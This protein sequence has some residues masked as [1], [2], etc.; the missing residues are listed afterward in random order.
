MSSRAGK[1]KNQIAQQKMMTV[2]QILSIME[3]EAE[4]MSWFQRWRIGQSFL[5]K[6]NIDCFF[7]L[8]S[9]NKKKK[10]KKHAEVQ[11]N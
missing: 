4:Q 8:A 6:K 2:V 1:V 7:D 10:E 11:N 9:K 5:W 3:N